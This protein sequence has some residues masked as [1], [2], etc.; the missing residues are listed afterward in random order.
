MCVCESYLTNS[1]RQQ[2]KYTD[3]KDRPGLVSIIVSSDFRAHIGLNNN[4]TV[5]LH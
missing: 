5:G 1:N 2:Q 4:E 3:F